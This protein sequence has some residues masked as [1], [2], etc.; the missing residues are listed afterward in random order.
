MRFKET[1]HYDI[2]ELGTAHQ[3]TPLMELE[4]FWGINAK[5]FHRAEALLIQ[6][7]FSCPVINITSCFQ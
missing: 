3:Q 1:W 5:M 7:A 2:K 6:S 4:S